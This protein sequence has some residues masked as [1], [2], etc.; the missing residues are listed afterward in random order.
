LGARPRRSWWS[1]W[2]KA[3]VIAVVVVLA[4][5]IAGA[6]VAA[7]ST[8]SDRSCGTDCREMGPYRDTWEKSAHS[9]TPC[10]QC[11]IPPGAVNF[12][13]TRL[14]ASREVWV[15]VT[16]QVKVPI[17]VTRHVPNSS[18]Q[19]GG[20]HTTG[21]TSGDITLG[22]PAPVAFQHG[23]EGHLKQ[24]C[25][26]CHAS[27]THEGAPG[28]TAPPA[29]SMPSCFS[30]HTDGPKDCGYCHKP[31]HGDRADC[32]GLMSWSGGKGGAHPGGRLT[33]KHGQISCGTCHKGGFGQ[34]AGCP[35]HGGKPPSGDRAAPPPSGGPLRRPS[36]PS[37]DHPARAP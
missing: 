19:R 8:E 37:R 33:G 28:V 3:I 31:P 36:G 10:V 34:L 7:K 6:A 25:I 17:K 32:H 35:C 11:H 29:N 15:P 20:C 27:L 14:S 16:G 5:L 1:R 22:S 2:W 26:A 13:E 23:S 24:L 30:C 4:L 9:G 18:C 12:V 21:Q